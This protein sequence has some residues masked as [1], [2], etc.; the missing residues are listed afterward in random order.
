MNKRNLIQFEATAQCAKNSIRAA[1]AGFLLVLACCA[2]S[3]A[4]KA[5]TPT[6]PPTVTGGVTKERLMT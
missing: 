5:Q 2:L 6:P 1:V 3:P 4:A